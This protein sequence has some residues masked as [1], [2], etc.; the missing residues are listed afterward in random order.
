MKR[1][2]G[3]EGNLCGSMKT[4]SKILSKQ[5]S[6][7]SGM[8][9][10]GVFGTKIVPVGQDV[11]SSHHDTLDSLPDRL[12]HT[13]MEDGGGDHRDRQSMIDR[14]ATKGIWL[15]PRATKEFGWLEGCP[16]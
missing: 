10:L 6:M 4:K 11:T 14:V 5:T 9:W 7:P 8:C 1:T 15:R 3:R 12:R 13:H 16:S 2:F